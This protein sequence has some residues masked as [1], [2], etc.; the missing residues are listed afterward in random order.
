MFTLPMWFLHPDI[1]SVVR[2]RLTVCHFL[3]ISI[4]DIR[5]LNL[6]C[7]YSRTW[8]PFLWTK[9]QAIFPLLQKLLIMHTCFF[10]WLLHFNS[11]LGHKRLTLCFP[12]SRQSLLNT[13][14]NSCTSSPAGYTCINLHSI[15]LKPL[16]QQ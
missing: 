11:K 2:D 4:C 7:H 8:P 13:G 3:P 6:S 9:L 16:T 12:Q 1:P 10:P 15:I 14:F 5:P